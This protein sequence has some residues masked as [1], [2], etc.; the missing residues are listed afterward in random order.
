MFAPGSPAWVHQGG[1]HV[2]YFSVSVM[3]QTFVFGIFA[4]LFPFSVYFV[5]KRGKRTHSANWLLYLNGFMFMLSV[6]YWVNS[7]LLL[8]LVLRAY[9]LAPSQALLDKLGVWASLGNAIITINYVIADGVVVW[10]AWVLCRADAGRWLYLPVF[11]LTLSSLSVF[12]TIIIRVS[13]IAVRVLHGNGPEPSRMTRAIDITQVANMVFTLITN[14]LAT[15]FIG[16][17]A[18]KHRALMQRS[19]KVASNR[20][21]KA[22]A[23]LGLVVESGL[24]YCLST[25][26]M[27]GSHGTQVTVIVA[28]LIRL[29]SGT[30]GD[31]YIPVNVQLAGMYPTV[32]LL[33]VGMNTTL[34]QMTTTIESS[35]PTDGTAIEFG[36]PY[37]TEPGRRGPARAAVLALQDRRSADTETMSLGKPLPMTPGPTEEKFRVINIGREG[38]PNEPLASQRSSREE[39]G[40]Y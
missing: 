35:V 34:H 4:I 40:M 3:C 2:L 39:E 27:Q 14:L 25:C 12:A 18:W 19:M 23:V 29:P 30:L 13:I 31:I 8:Y 7:I 17:K 32:V 10:R 6:V 28:M 37:G 20:G 36:T 26:A 1:K 24:I 16:I 15:A 22:E 9:F 5:R 11:F 33:I 38:L 21:Q